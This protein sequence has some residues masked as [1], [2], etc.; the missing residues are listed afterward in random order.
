MT[1]VSTTFGCVAMLAAGWLVGEPV[2][3]GDWPQFR[4]PGGAGVS[5]DAGVPLEWSDTRNLRWKVDLPG[6][7][8]SSPIVW[9][10]RVF[11]TC[12]SGYGV[13][14]GGDNPADLKRHL[15]CVNRTS[16]DVAWT[17]TV[18]ALQ[19]EDPYRGFI[20]EH[21]YASSTPVT[22]GR[23]VFVFFGKT[24]VLAFDM[25]GNKLWETNVGK[26]SSGR[27]WGSAA[28]PLLYKDLVIVN[29]A[30][31]SQSVRALKQDTGEEVWKSEAALLELSYATPGLVSLADGA[32]EIVVPVQ[33]EV[34][35]LHADTGKLKWFCESGINGNVCP[36]ALVSG[37]VAY[38]YGGLGGRTGVAVRAGGTKDVTASHVLWHGSSGSYVGTPVLH[39][40]HLYWITDGGVARCV[41]AADGKQ[42][43]EQ[44]TPVTG[45]SA[46]YASPL[47][48]GGR[49]YIV[50][51]RGGTL[52][53]AA[54]PAY[55]QL[56]LNTFASDDSDFNGSPAVSDGQMFLRSN[57]RLYCVA[58]E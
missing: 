49:I 24:G 43:Y 58:S 6:A 30:E 13:P 42:V 35:G 26:E 2:A 37:D 7:G 34:W 40:G 18:D 9:G 57:R 36:S 41:N 3:A 21:G 44:R 38:V 10:D 54:K 17:A 52:V 32:S 39:E 46:F 15:V 12:Y 55:E 1:R 8:S 5:S 23:R 11:V 50:S 53:L 16:G 20:T 14:G 22:D 29:A 4:G 48:A 25:D 27:R 33:E 47:V 45:R 56:A 51:R 19:P 28:S 31:E